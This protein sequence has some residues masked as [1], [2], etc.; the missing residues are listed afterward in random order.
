MC[1]YVL[2]KRK[3][4]DAKRLLKAVIKDDYFM[5]RVKAAKLL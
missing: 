3:F 5:E 2:A 1:T 4:R